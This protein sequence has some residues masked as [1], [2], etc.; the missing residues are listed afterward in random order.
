MPGS[1]K[2]SRLYGRGSRAIARQALEEAA[3]DDAR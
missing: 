3:I 1:M 2:T